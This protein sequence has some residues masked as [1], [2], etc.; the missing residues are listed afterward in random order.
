MSNKK[1]LWVRERGYPNPFYGTEKQFRIYLRNWGL[2]IKLEFKTF[3][4]FA[5]V[6]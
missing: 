4:K 6:K 2:N 5:K 1:Y 3:M